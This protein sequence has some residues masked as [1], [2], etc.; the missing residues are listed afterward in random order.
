MR[1]LGLFDAETGVPVDSV[2]V[3]EAS[4]G[5]KALTSETGTVSL[6][7][8]RDGGGLLRLAKAGYRPDTLTVTL[9]PRDT[10]PLTVILVKI[11]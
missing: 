8:M 7:F 11:K 10:T 6:A 5:T 2:E 3:E 1:I 4:T 9:S